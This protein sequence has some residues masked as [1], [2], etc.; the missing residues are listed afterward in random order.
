MSTWN[1][2]A[3]ALLLLLAQHCANLLLQVLCTTSTLAMGV[4]LPAHL[5]VSLLLLSQHNSGPCQTPQH[6][7]WV[8]QCTAQCNV[9]MSVHCK[10]DARLCAVSCRS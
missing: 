4:N 10:A 6:C 2:N 5:V 8:M 7:V 1:I 3:Q 9:Y